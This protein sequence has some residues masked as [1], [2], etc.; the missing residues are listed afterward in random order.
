MKTDHIPFQMPIRSFAL[1]QEW[2]HLSFLLWI[3]DKKYILPYIPKGLELDTYN[4]N[5]YI[6]TIPFLMKDVMPRFLPSLNYIS[7]FPEFNIR[8]YV[9]YKNKSGVF[10][11]T[12]DAQ[13]KITCLF[14]P[15]AYGLPYR[16]AKGSVQSKN[17][18][19][20]WRSK[21]LSDSAELKGYCKPFGEHMTA[22]RGSLEEF[23]FER[24]CLF[25]LINNNLCIGYVA[26]KPW[27][28]QIGKAKLEI[29][30]FTGAYNLGIKNL[31]MPDL[32]HISDGVKVKTWSIETL[33]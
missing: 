25:T 8:T 29:N 5:A 16:Y 15:Y 13:S 3:V 7:T 12:L 24:Y 31:L 14:A 19:Y 23:L 1:N 30:S 26:H 10:F 18:T 9:K 20:S 28:Y 32:V 27:V 22:S 11:L 2:R 4:N 33:K 17:M 21:R 6:S